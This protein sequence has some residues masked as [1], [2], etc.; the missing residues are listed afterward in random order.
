M[1]QPVSRRDNFIWLLGGLVFLL[2]SGA[3]LA[4]YGVPGGQ[5]LINISI[6]VALLVAVWSMEQQ[7]DHWL[8]SR[9]GLSLVVAA[10]M[11]GDVFLKDARLTLVQ[12]GFIFVFLNLTTY[13]ACRQ[14]LFS[15]NVDGNK[16]IGAICIYL[17]M[18]LGWA[19]GYL[20]IEELYPGSLSG[21][22]HSDWHDN[23]QD[24]IYFSFVTLTTLGYGDISA[25]LPLARFISY[26]EAITGQFYIA[27]LVASL[28]GIRLSNVQVQQNTNQSQL[29]RRAEDVESGV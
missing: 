2:F 17:M 27:I 21:L 23:L 15:G 5:R 3:L 19:F 20:L 26:M 29:K 1:L 18:A 11:I 12:L 16:I 22:D 4:Q 24:V 6:S 7:R 28:I 13:L 14:V 9:I 8:R 25:V 10:L